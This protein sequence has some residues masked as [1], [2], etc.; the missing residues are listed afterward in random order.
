MMK[1]NGN[2]K[3]HGSNRSTKV[4]SKDNGIRK[5]TMAHENGKKTMREIS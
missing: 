2:G 4:K 5:S 3:N 1:D